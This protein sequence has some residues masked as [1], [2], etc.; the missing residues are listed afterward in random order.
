MVM[1]CLTYDRA[2]AYGEELPRAAYETWQPRKVMEQLLAIDPYADKDRSMAFGLEPA[3][4]EPPE[5]MRSLGTERVLGMAML[6][7]HY[8][9]LGSYL[10]MP[11]VKQAETGGVDHRRMRERCEQTVAFVEEVFR[12]R[13]FNSTIGTFLRNRLHAVREADPTAPAPRRYR[14]GACAVS[15]VRLHLHRHAHGGGRALA[16]APAG[17]ALRGREVRPA[18]GSLGGRGES[19]DMVD[20]HRLQHAQLD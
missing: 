9:A 2:R 17:S 10:H 16:S 3:P 1:E 6:K 13:F 12:S 11:T 4:G 18:C 20:L 7:K 5:V 14:G 19:R 15:R 8:D